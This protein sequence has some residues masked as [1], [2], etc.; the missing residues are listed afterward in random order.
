MRNNYKVLEVGAAPGKWM[1]L[2]AEDGFAVSG[3]EYSTEGMKILKENLKLLEV[4]PLD[5]IHGDFF[6]IEP[7]P[8]YDVVM[9]FGFIE[10]FEDA[11][12]VIARHKNWLKP[13][14]LLIIGVPNFTGLHGGIQKMLDKSVYYS[15]NT[16]IMNK[17]FFAD[18]VPTALSLEI[19]SFDYLGSFEPSLPMSFQKINLHNVIPK[20]IIRLG[21]ILRKWRGF[22]KFNSAFL[23]SY[24]LAIYRNSE[25]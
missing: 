12:T 9:S 15:H 14:G 16:K 8:I 21:L 2:M 18:K 6:S 5:L 1:H 4:E 25:V 7:R 3:I 13:N 11:E 22:D 23:S 24:L 19:L 10:H 20:L 17:K